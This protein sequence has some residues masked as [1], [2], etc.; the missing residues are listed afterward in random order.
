V[1]GSRG[2][3]QESKLTFR[4]GCHANRNHKDRCGPTGDRFREGT[5][6]VSWP[7]IIRSVSAIELLTPRPIPSVRGCAKTGL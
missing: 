6:I 1:T 4:G 7:F 5:D 2:I 3:D